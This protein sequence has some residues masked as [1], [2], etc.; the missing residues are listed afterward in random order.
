M[1][2]LRK[3]PIVKEEFYV[4]RDNRIVK[5]FLITVN[6]VAAKLEK[7][8]I[9]AGGWE[10]VMDIHVG[11]AKCAPEDE[12]NEVYGRHLAERRAYAK[13]RGEVNAELR[14]AIEVERKKLETLEKYGFLKRAKGWKNG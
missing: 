10:D 6:D 8:G 13:R 5:C 2:D 1:K 14:R 3:R 11:I 4:D 9:A 12:W 7:Y